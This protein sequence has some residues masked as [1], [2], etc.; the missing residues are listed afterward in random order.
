MNRNHTKKAC[1]P[2]RQAFIIILFIVTCTVSFAQNHIKT[3][4]LKNLLKTVNINER[5]K[6]LN[7]LAKE[8]LPNFPEKAKKNASL[9]LQ[10]ARK[11]NNRIEQAFALKYIGVALYYQSEYEK[12]L[13][14]YNN[15]M[16]IFKELD[17]KPEIA[18]LFNN[19]GLIY[20]ELNNYEKALEYFQKVLKTD[21]KNKDKRGVAYSLNNIGL[22]YYELNNYEDAL[23]YFQ[24]SLKKEKEIDNKNGLA[25]SLNNIGIIYQELNNYEDALEYYQKSLK[26]KEEIKDKKGI[27]N[28]LNNIGIIY[29]ELNNYEEALEYHQKSLQIRGEIKDKRGIASSLNNIG[30]L[31]NKLGNFNKA[32]LY[33]GK[34]LEMSEFLDAK[35]MIIDNYKFI[36][37]TYSAT[38]NYRK[39]F[40]YHKQYT[41]LK[42]SVF[43]LETYKQIADMKTKYETEKKD[44]QIQTLEYEN[45]IKT[46]KIKHHKKT[47][48]IY[49]TGLLLTLIAITIILI[50]LRK[51]NRAYKFLVSKNLDVLSKEKELKNIKE[52]LQIGNT[53]SQNNVHNDEKEKIL[54][55]LE[56][57]FETDK[58]FTQH[59][60][61]IDKLAKKLSINKN[62]LSG[63]INNEYKK[64]YNDFINEYRVKEAMLLLSDKKNK[65]YTVEAIAKEAGFRSL[66]TFNPVFK[67]YTGLTPSKFL[68]T[69]NL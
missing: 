53:Y 39:A 20:K 22:I 12:A 54:R 57:L 2:N 11:Q 60:L 52:N 46:I 35:D 55:R 47:H 38:G 42:D 33:F 6:L 32:L 30:E 67:K 34:S 9:A 3:D 13:E 66:S 56:R 36:S 28:T 68:K 48:I 25:K 65:K 27:A 51:K 24:K 17:N 14:N 59:S 37:E 16:Q 40:E 15:S 31:Y 8:Y 4:S 44:K 23:E 41:G 18:K 1:L 7:E 69:L 61:T 26:I 10:F 63:V 29:K 49:I 62:Y 45:N 19:T 64:N 21:K 43:S 58:S 5:P 50:L